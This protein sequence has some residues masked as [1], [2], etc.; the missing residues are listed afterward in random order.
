MKL[1]SEETDLGLVKTSGCTDP[2]GD[3]PIIQESVPSPAAA[4][5]IGHKG[6]QSQIPG[7]LDCGSQD[8]LV[9]GA[10]ASPPPRFYFSPVRYVSA[11]LLHI[12]VVN[13]IYMVYTKGTHTPAG[14]EAASRP[15]AGA[16]APTGTGPPWGSAAGSASGSTHGWS[17]HI[18]TVLQICPFPIP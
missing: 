14:G 8:A 15:S 7:T 2:N 17:S 11:Y 1:G 12:L 18:V 16:A 13:V 4:V 10:D 6:E 3:S 9:L 5:V